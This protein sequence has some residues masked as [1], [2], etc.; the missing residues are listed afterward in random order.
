[1]GSLSC[2][3]FARS[4]KSDSEKYYT[5][6]E[7]SDQKGKVNISVDALFPVVEINL[8]MIIGWAKQGGDHM[9]GAI[10]HH[11][12]ES[13]ADT[14]L[15]K[16]IKMESANSSGKNHGCKAVCGHQNCRAQHERPPQ[17]DVQQHQNS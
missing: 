16:P 3:A 17:A 9:I 12:T 14:C 1:M 13:C 6:K 5:D 2:F 10:E 8:I 7:E 15:E 11:S 4:E